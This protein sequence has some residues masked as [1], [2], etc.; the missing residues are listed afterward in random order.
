[1]FNAFYRGISSR[2]PLSPLCAYEDVRTTRIVWYGKENIKVDMKDVKT[3]VR[4]SVLPW[5][6][7]EIKRA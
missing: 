5:I 7:N 2:I 6:F 1:M 3:D 4:C